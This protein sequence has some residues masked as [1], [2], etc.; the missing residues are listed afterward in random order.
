MKVYPSILI[1]LT[2][3]SQVKATNK[4]PMSKLGLQLVLP[5]DPVKIVSDYAPWEIQQHEIPE[6][7]TYMDTSGSFSEIRQYLPRNATDEQMMT[8]LETNN[9][10][11]MRT[12]RTIAGGLPAEHPRLLF[13]IFKNCMSQCFKDVISKGSRIG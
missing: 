10:L 9:R 3:L 13:W 6:V 2:A 12:M 11:S 1:A 7:D 8:L 4:K 5:L